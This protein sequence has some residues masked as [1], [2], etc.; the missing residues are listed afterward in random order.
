MPTPCNIRF[1]QLLQLEAEF[2]LLHDG[3]DSIRSKQLA[4]EIVTMGA[5]F[6]RRNPECERLLREDSQ[7][8]TE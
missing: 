4:A 7:T 3:G 5:E 1:K 2:T 6:N 8:T